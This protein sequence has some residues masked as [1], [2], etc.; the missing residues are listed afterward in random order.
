[1]EVYRIACPNCGYETKVPIGSSDLDQILT[2]TNADYAEYRL[3]VCR[4]EAKF[5]H[6]NI[7]DKL[8]ERKCP[9]DG[10]D[11]SEVNELPPIKCPRCKKE[12]LIAEASKPMDERGHG[13]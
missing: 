8:F 11:L 4:K 10:S 5:V 9:A 12:G 13:E 6:A 3:F 1:M 2:D 7:H